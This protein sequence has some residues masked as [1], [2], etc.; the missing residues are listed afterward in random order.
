MPLSPELAVMPEVASKFFRSGVA[1]ELIISLYKGDQN[2]NLIEDARRVVSEFKKSEQICIRGIENIKSG[3]LIVFN[4]P[5]SDVILPGFLELMVNLHD[6]QK[7]DM[8][9]LMATE[10]MLFANLNDKKEIPGSI[11]FMERFHRMYGA[12]IISTPTVESRKDFLTGRMVALRKIIR[13]LEAGNTIGLSPEGHVEIEGAISPIDTF[14]EGSGAISRMA[15]KR[16]IP[17]IPVGIWAWRDPKKIFVHVG[18]GF[19]PSGESNNLAVN[20]IMEHIAN[21]MPFDLRGPFSK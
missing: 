19:Y 8:R 1:K 9:L 5:N 12:A 6:R 14:H 15:A 7:R 13:E 17:T 11:G 4:H 21:L 18:K 10:I 3:A 2:R 16:G 20:D